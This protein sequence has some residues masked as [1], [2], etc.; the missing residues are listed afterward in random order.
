MLLCCF[1]DSVN[2]LDLQNFNPW[3]CLCHVW[4][5]Y[6][7]RQHLSIGV[8]RQLW[9]LFLDLLI[10]EQLKQCCTPSHPPACKG[11]IDQQS[12]CLGGPPWSTT[13]SSSTAQ[14]DSGSPSRLV[15]PHCPVSTPSPPPPLLLPENSSRFLNASNQPIL[16]Y[17]GNGMY[18]MHV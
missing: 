15:P 18:S 4:Q 16:A 10:T 6:F 8:N 13:T 14:Q 17:S 9:K 11:A 1:D 7:S 5:C 3:V 12:A 2:E